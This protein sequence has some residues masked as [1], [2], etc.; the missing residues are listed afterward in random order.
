MSTTLIGTR[1]ATRRRD[2]Q[3]PVPLRNTLPRYGGGVSW[4]E[5]FQVKGTVAWVPLNRIVKIET[6]PASKLE[7]DLGADYVVLA[8]LDNGEEVWL[9][10]FPTFEDAAHFVRVRLPAWPSTKP[11]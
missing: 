8:T 11:A 4:V 1:H 9:G 2:M 6:H 7:E 3:R 5:G 10:R